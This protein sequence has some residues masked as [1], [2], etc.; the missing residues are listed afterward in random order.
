MKASMRRWIAAVVFASAALPVVAF[1]LARPAWGGAP[2]SEAPSRTLRDVFVVAE[3]AGEGERIGRLGVRLQTSEGWEPVSPLRE[4]HAGD[5]FRFEVK[6]SRAAWVYLFHQ[7]PG[8][9]MKRL[10]P[11]AGAPRDIN[12]VRP[13]VIR[14]IPDAGVFVFDE[15]AGDERFYVVLRSSPQAPRVPTTRVT[16]LGRAKSAEALPASLPLAPP[17]TTIVPVVPAGGA[18]V[19]FIVRGGLEQS[20]ARGVLYV[21]DQSE[22]DP[23]LYFAAG[24]A[25]TR[26]DAVLEVRLNHK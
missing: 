24:H 15:H 23:S 26:G 11:P 22:S 8:A 17:A 18:I 3:K 5:R 7:A 10:W 25:A 6:T 4:F 21:P 20:G 13:G 2:S 12:K 16:A 14:E 19:N 1:L 9:V